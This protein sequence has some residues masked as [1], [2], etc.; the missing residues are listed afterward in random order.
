L[1]WL[2]IVYHLLSCGD[3]CHDLGV[4]HF[5]EGRRERLEHGFVQRL[6]LGLS[7]PSSMAGAKTCK[8]VSAWSAST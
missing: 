2:D 1:C 5:D 6:D 8:P 7:A 3:V 4:Q